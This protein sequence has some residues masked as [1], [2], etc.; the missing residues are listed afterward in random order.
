MIHPNAYADNTA[1]QSLSKDL[2]KLGYGLWPA[3]TRRHVLDAAAD[4]MKP[5][6]T[7][8]LDAVDNRANLEEMANFRN[9]KWY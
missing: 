2:L 7:A 5:T 9:I 4:V 1:S 3:A 8:T 6:E